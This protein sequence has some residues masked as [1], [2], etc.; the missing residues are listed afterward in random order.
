MARFG[1]FDNMLACEFLC[2][3]L[4]KLALNSTDKEFFKI[5]SVI[6]EVFNYEGLMDAIWKSNIGNLDRF[7][8]NVKK[9]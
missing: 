4:Q 6:D 7:I 5:Y 8:D 3:R 9:Q 1:K 2:E